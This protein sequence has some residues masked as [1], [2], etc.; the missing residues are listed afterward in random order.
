ME[1]VQKSTLRHFTIYI[2]E[3]FNRSALF[4]T[5]ETKELLPVV[6][7]NSSNHTLS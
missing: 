6:F 3:L 7:R 4:S 1:K 5:I 2:I